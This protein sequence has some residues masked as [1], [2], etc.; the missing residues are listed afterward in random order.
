MGEQEVV[1]ERWAGR[2]GEG[3]GHEIMWR[4]G[5]QAKMP[6]WTA[7]CGRRRLIQGEPLTFLSCLQVSQIGNSGQ[8]VDKKDE[9]LSLFDHKKAH[10]LCHTK[11]VSKTTSGTR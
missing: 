7:A 1:F 3:K 8:G 6:R 4:V 9:P 5:F 2:G 11:L 10:D